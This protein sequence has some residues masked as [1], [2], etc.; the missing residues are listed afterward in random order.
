M[1]PFE[2]ALRETLGIEGGF[3]N[4]PADL[5]GAT[6]WG[7]TEEVAR[8]HG[9][10]G[11]MRELPLATAMA[12]YRADYWDANRLEDIARYDERVAVEVFDTG[13]NMGVRMAAQFLQRALNALN[14]GQTL[15][16]DLAVD[17]AIGPA[18]LGAL[19]HLGRPLD[20]ETLLKMLNALQGARYIELCEARET[21]ERFV[22]GWFRRVHG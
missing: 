1:T 16:G 3:V 2:T 11:D 4:D 10:A 9:Y 17:G 13:V 21:N 14:R 12:I 6:N 5:G 20:K 22:R 19:A 15:F 18:T 7:I 8:R